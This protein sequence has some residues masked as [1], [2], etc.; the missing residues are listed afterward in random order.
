M[1]RVLLAVPPR[2]RTTGT[3]GPKGTIPGAGNSTKTLYRPTPA[4]LVRKKDS[5]TLAGTPPIV[6]VG[7][8]LVRPAL[9]DVLEEPVGGVVLTAPRPLHTIISVSVGWA[10]FAP[11]GTWSVLVLVP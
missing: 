8:S 3:A 7:V 2:E 10:G 11:V 6:T 5:V 9:D 1:V 4:A